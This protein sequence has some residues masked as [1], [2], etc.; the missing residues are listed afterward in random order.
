MSAQCLVCSTNSEKPF[1][2]KNGHDVFRCQ[3]CGFMYVWPV[4][5]STD[6]VYSQEY[7]QGAR[8][9]FGYVNYQED[10]AGMRST[11][12]R[13]LAKINEMVPQ[14]GLLLDVGAATGFF[15]GIAKDNG[16]NASGVEISGWASQKGREAG[17]DIITGLISDTDFGI[18]TFDAVTFL[19]VF[20]HVPNPRAELKIVKN[21]LKTS[22]V[23]AMN[24]PDG[25]SV[26]AR[27]MGSRW[28]SF[29]P[30]EH[31]NYFNPIAIRRVLEEEGFD[32]LLI[33]K[34]GKYFTFQY[35]FQTL[36]RWQKLNL[37]GWLASKAKNSF[38]GR[39]YIPLN[40][41]DNMFVLARKRSF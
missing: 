27:F 23:L 13:F 19:D 30:P 34:I 17:H 40:L 26:F 11:F 35:I 41:R 9:G 39:W 16:W 12:E 8:Q 37:W 31:L 33:D 15:M 2:N 38:W 21:I 36:Y 14:K 1:T 10:K 29:V 3:T 24:L 25:G 18:G 28:H 20:E 6:E 5:V 4:P 22:G 7:F 32:V